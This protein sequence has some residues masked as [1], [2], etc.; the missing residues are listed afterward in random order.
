[1]FKKTYNIFVRDFY[2]IEW[3][4]GHRAGVHLTFMQH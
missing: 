1:V 2:F 3:L 4:F